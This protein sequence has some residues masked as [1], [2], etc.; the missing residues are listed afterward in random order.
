MYRV[1]I[2]LIP[3]IIKGSRP[4]QF[5]GESFTAL[6]YV[7]KIAYKI[8]ELIREYNKFGDDL[9]A[10][11]EK[12]K[13]DEL[14]T[15]DVFERKIEQMVTD[16]LDVLKL[17]YEEQDSFIANAINNIIND[18]P[19]ILSKTLGE[20]YA[21]GEFDTIVYN[22]VENLKKEFDSIVKNTT[23]FQNSINRSFSNLSSD[24]TSFKSEITNIVD[25]I[26][27]E[28]EERFNNL[29]QDVVQSDMKSSVYDTNKNGIVDN[30]EALG[31]QPAEYYAKKQELDN[32]ASIIDTLELYYSIM[33]Q[34][35]TSISRTATNANTV[36]GNADVRSL[37][38]NSRITA[39]ESDVASSKTYA[40]TAKGE[41][42]SFVNLNA[43]TMSIIPISNKIGSDNSLFHFDNNGYIVIDKTGN[44]VISAGVYIEVDRTENNQF[45][46]TSCFVFKNNNSEVANEI[47]SATDKMLMTT[48]HIGNRV[49]RVSTGIKC[50]ALNKGD[51]I[52]LYARTEQTTGKVYLGNA[53]TYLTI[54]NVV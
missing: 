43:D 36:A 40:M 7:S 48:E 2:D 53:A 32:L 16:F 54:M 51:K 49:S 19:N 9:I 42:N 11:F 33:D 17:K 38:N 14:I 3:A 35:I 39:L 4:S 12:F 41:S 46:A 23:S 18:L 24:I 28:L 5:E 37:N 13:N 6:E 15:R 25:G 8:N 31:G 50:V 10:E 45:S 30:S 21:D 29:E 1:P 22:S 20:M 47:V 44:Y 34:N 52:Y 26:G 27:D